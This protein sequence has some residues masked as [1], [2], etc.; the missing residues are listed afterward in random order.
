MRCPGAVRGMGSRRGGSAT[1]YTSW[2]PSSAAGWER[3]SS[4]ITLSARSIQVCE[5]PSAVVG[6]SSPSSV[7][8]AAS[9]RARSIF[10]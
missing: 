8:A 1:R 7:I 10:P 5:Q 9:M 4:T 2:K 3:F 6:T